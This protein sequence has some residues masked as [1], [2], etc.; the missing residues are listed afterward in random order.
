MS[1]ENRKGIGRSANQIEYLTPGRIIEPVDD[2]RRAHPQLSGAQ[3]FA[4][5]SKHGS[6]R[7]L[8]GA[9]HQAKG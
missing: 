1:T 3:I 5:L 9:T 8:I 7:S 4:G 6:D 2:R